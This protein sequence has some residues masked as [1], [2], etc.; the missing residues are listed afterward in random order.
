MIDQLQCSIIDTNAL[1]KERE[2]GKR[3]IETHSV[4]AVFYASILS[5]SF[6]KDALR[7]QRYSELVHHNVIIIERP[8]IEYL[9]ET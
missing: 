7:H 3:K 9:N 6:P 4:V 2:V 1:L 8:Q 5:D